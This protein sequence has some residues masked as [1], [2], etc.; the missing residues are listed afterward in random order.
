MREFGKR[1]AL[2]GDALEP[3]R[4]LVPLDVGLAGLQQMGRH[5]NRLVAHALRRHQS[6]RARHHRVAAGI[7]ADAEGDARGVREGHG[8]LL[9]RHL[10]LVRHHLGQCGSRALA[11]RCCAA[12]HRHLAAAV[13]AHLGALVRP[14]GRHLGVDADA[15]P[16][17]LALLAVARLRGPEPGVIEGIERPL[18]PRGEVAGIEHHGRFH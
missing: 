18:Q 1:V 11:L 3:R 5:R 7:S 6:R 2:L 16:A 13:D 15:E 4:P 9:Q 10:K 12:H 14:D 8:D 17:Q